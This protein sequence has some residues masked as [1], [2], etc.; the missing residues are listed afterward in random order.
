VTF[1]LTFSL[2]FYI[3]DIPDI[4]SGILSGIYS[5]ILCGMC[6]GPGALHCT[7]SWQRER[8]TRRPRRRRRRGGEEEKEKEEKEKTEEESHLY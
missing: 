5:D 7:R 1:F 6:S 8:T 3:S 4:P 2:A